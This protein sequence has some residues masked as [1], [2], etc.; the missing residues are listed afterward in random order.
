MKL[1]DVV[2][3]LISNKYIV[4][5]KGKYKF[6]ELFN[7]EMT[8]IA[9]GLTLSGGVSEPYLPVTQQHE[10]IE[11]SNLKDYKQ[12]DW[13]SFYEKFLELCNIPRR[14]VGSDGRDYALNKYSETGMKAFQKAIKDGYDPLLLVA[15]VKLYYGSSLG[16]KKTITNYL[17]DGD[18]RTDYI[19]VRDSN[20]RG[21]LKQTIDEE[22]STGFARPRIG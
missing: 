17:K 2:E 4:T 14:S 7:K 15:T 13:V 22:T 1:L 21:G 20:E 19:L 3:F 18:W 16:Y 8:G 11:L 9:K 12:A 5:H 6:T 10:Q